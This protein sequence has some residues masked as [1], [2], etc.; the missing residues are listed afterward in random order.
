MAKIVISTGNIHFSLPLSLVTTQ[1]MPALIA[2]VF[3]VTPRKPPMMSTKRATSMAPNSSPEFQTLTF[4][5]ASSMPYM[6]LIGPMSALTSS[7]CGFDGTC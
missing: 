3:I 6:P 2:P 7:F 1:A 5:V 4:P